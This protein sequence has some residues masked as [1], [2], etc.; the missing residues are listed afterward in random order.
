V[1]DDSTKILCLTEIF[2]KERELANNDSTKILF[3]TE[4]FEKNPAKG[5]K[6][7]EEKRKKIRGRERKSLFN[8]LKE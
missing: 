4:I 1:D 8:K 3:L 2:E 6:K 7:R 5:K